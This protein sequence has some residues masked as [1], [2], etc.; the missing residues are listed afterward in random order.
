MAGSL[1]LLFFFVNV[2]GEFYV[3]YLEDGVIDEINYMVQVGQC[4][5]KM[6]YQVS[7]VNVL[8]SC[9]YSVYYV[10]QFEFCKK[11]SR[12]LLIIL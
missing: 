2:R 11:N 6:G 5:V 10:V 1:Y 9:L 7:G 12:Q 3:F 4:Q 8:L